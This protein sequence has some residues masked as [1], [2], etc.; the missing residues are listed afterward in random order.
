MGEG[1]RSPRRG[2]PRADPATTRRR[3]LDAASAQFEE[4]GYHGTDTNKIARAAGLAPATFYRHFD[5]KLAVFLDTYAAR[6]EAEWEVIEAARR[7][8][9][10][11][12]EVARAIATAMLEHHARWRGVRASM[13]ALVATD[14]RARRAGDALR[15]RQI[16]RLGALVDPGTGLAAEELTFSFLAI[17]RANNAVTDGDLD[18]FGVDR[19]AFVARLE[20]EIV[21]LLTGERS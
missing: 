9:G 15:R 19:A 2:R 20:R 14:E 11:P 21:H 13:H 7:T 18:A 12:A 6:V 17:E 10:T 4:H 1:E 5:D 16:E 3:L 8:T